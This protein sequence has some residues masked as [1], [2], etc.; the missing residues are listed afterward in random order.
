ML[1]RGRAIRYTGLGK[2]FEMFSADP[3]EKALVRDLSTVTRPAE[4][5]TWDSSLD[6]TLERAKAGD[7]EAFEEIYKAMYSPLAKFIYYKIGEPGMVE[8]V[9]NETFLVAWRSLPEFR[10]GHFPGWL[11]RIARNLAVGEIRKKTR[12]PTAPL[13][14]AESILD[15]SRGPEESA[16]ASRQRAV[17]R[18]ALAKLN[19]DQREIVVLKYLLGWTNAE[20]ADALGKSENAVNAQQHRALRSLERHLSKEGLLDG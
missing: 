10:G 8:D 16:E 13:E 9:V 17:L 12:R 6:A 4:A 19:E 7:R 20:V 1:S 15:T 3:N 14:E 11:Y 18:N 2:K 5:P